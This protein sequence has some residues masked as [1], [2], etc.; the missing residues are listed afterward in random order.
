MSTVKKLQSES[1]KQQALVSNIKQLMQNLGIREAE[2]SRLTSI[3]LTTLHKIL[4]GKTIDP[5]V[6]TLQALADYFD[7]TIDELYSGVLENKTQPKLHSIPILNWEDC[8]QSKHCI[9]NLTPSNWNSWLTTE[10]L[11][12]NAYGLTSKLSMEPRFPRGTTLIIDPEL[13]AEDGDLVVVIYPSTEDATLRQLL[14][15]GPN[16]SL[17]S[18]DGDPIKENLSEDIQIVGVVIESKFTW[19]KRN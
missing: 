13:Q 2:L 17:L 19:S 8:F 1:A 7:T 11:A 12:P 6:S 9:K 4:S 10:Y 16:Q 15:D 5:R 3:P 14:K 18:I